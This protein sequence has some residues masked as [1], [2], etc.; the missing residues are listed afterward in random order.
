MTSAATVHEVTQDSGGSPIHPLGV[1][2]PPPGAPEPAALEPAASGTAPGRSTARSTASAPSPSRALSGS[3]DSVGQYLREIGKVALLDAAHEV[4]LARAIEAGVLAAERLHR[5]DTNDTPATGAGERGLGAELRRDLY[6][7]ARAGERARDDLV[8][9]NL[10]LVVS[11]AKRYAGR[12]MPF[13]DLVQEGNLGLIRAVQKFDYTK[14]FKFS[15]YA[16]W[17]IRQ[18]IARAMADQ[19][20]TIRVPAHMAEIITT[21]K[22][23]E[24]ELE[25]KLGRDP[26]LTE[27]ATAFGVTPARVRELREYDLQPISLDQPLGTDAQATLAELVKDSRAAAPDAT[28]TSDLRQRL[29]AL[30]ATLPERE[31]TLIRLRTGLADG[32]PHSHEHISHLDGRSRERIRQLE[33]KA[34]ATLRGPAT[35][36][37]LR[38]YLT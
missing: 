36:Q 20:R 8:E 16:T 14:G 33:N 28:T 15:T 17:W 9:A 23:A 30:L 21:L 22:K 27:L 10:R 4:E 25:Q 29:D 35:T 5:H 11:I 6:R 31:A 7:I 18:G 26:T 24:R 34:L 13:L 32:T 37:N 12:G 1:V 38:D 3:L 19:A 2:I